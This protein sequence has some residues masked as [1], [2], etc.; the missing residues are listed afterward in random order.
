MSARGRKRV[1]SDVPLIIDVDTGAKRKRTAD[2][3]E[4]EWYP[5]PTSAILPL[6]EC[7]EL[8]LPGGLWIDPCAGTGRIPAVV[9]ATRNDV[10]W[11]LVELDER[12]RPHLEAAIRPGDELL[13][14]GDFVIRPWAWPRARVAIMNPPFS[15]AQVFVEACLDRAEIVVMLQRR[16]WIA[17]A[18]AD[19]LRGRMPDEYV[20]AE[21]PSFTGDGK[22]DAAE[23][24]WF[25]WGA[26]GAGSVRR[27]VGEV[28]MLRVAGAAR[29]VDMFGGA[30]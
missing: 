1:A 12:H 21:R 24:S 10:R 26:G 4:A 25:V 17:P 8:L 15:H 28:R 16:N 23:Y 7:T 14:F 22:T 20:L 27:N 30:A 11:L 29:Q 9:N 19:W 18:R 3:N 2:A 13:P 6:L 5:T